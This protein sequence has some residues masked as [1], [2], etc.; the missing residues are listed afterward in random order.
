M[1]GIRRLDSGHILTDLTVEVEGYRDLQRA[2]RSAPADT[3]KEVRKGL[4]TAATTVRDDARRRAPSRSGRLRRSLRVSVT[5]RGVAVGSRLPYAAIHEFGGRHP[6]FGD[7]DNWYA[8]RARP[9]LFPAARA[10]QATTERELREAWFVAK[11]KAG[12]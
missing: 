11:R 4:R 12:L 10:N 7:R 2:L 1:G 3:R 5:Q 9:F 6:L 8:Q